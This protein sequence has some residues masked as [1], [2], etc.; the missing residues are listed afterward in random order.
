MN[1]ATGAAIISEGDAITMTKIL[2]SIG[3]RQLLSCGRSPT[4]ENSPLQSPAS[5]DAESGI[6]ES[7]NNFDGNTEVHYLPVKLRGPAPPAQAD[8]LTPTKL[9]SLPS[10]PSPINTCPTCQIGTQVADLPEIVAW[11][12]GHWARRKEGSIAE[13]FQNMLRTAFQAGSAAAT[14][15]ET[16]EN[17]YER[18]ILQ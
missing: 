6:V 3:T 4:T 8:S 9:P 12:C 15:G 14:N 7:S 2:N 17:W 16:F 1:L 11:S 18:E 5:C 10:N 13:S